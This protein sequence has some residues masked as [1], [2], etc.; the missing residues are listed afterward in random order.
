VLL[1]A[2]Y[3]ATLAPGLTFWDA[4]ELIAAVETLGIPHPPGTPLFVVL[5]RAWSDVL[6]WL[7]RAHATNLLSAVCTAAAGGVL[8][9]VVTRWSGRVLMGIAAALAAGAMS[10][11][12]R[13]ATETEL[14][15][16]SLLLSMLMLAAGHRAGVTGSGK[17]LILTAYTFALAVPLHL[18]ALVAAPG[19]ALLAAQDTR[20]GIRWGDAGLLASAM[21]LSLAVGLASPALIAASLGVVG[22]A[23]VSQERRPPSRALGGIA[24]MVVAFSALA[25]MAARAVHEPAINS[26]NPRDWAALWDVVGRRQYGGHALWPRQ[27]PLWIQLGNLAEYADWQVALGLSPGVAPSLVR[28]PITLLFVALGIA[29]ASAH[30]RADPRSWRAMLL[31]LVAGSLALALYLNF[32][33]GASFGWGVLPDDAPHEARERDYFFTLA[34]WTWGAWAGMGAVWVFRRAHARLAPL[35]LALA[36]LPVLLNWSAVDRRGG[37]EAHLPLEVA[38]A[39]LASAPDRAVLV[40]AGDNDSFPL[41]YAQQVEQ[42]RPDVTVVVA[43]L[44]GARW[45]V[46]QL[47]RRDTL[48]DASVAR[49]ALGDEWSFLHAVGDGARSR[50]RPVA[51]ALNAGLARAQAVGIDEPLLRGLV[52]VQASA[53]EGARVRELPWLVD[54]ATTGRLAA[55]LPTIVSSRDAIDP[56]ARAFSALLDCPR[57]IVAAARAGVEPISLDS[58][59]NPR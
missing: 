49:S 35:G 14:Y 51:V 36:A 42:L 8:A 24:V 28:T 50:G 52:L 7:P 17:W 11:V 3:V 57:Q 47:A 18:G 58:R 22:A 33:P 21:L 46:E 27:A 20:G 34:L 54:T 6:A 19:A 37:A 25:I 2:L 38:R 59:C 10:T 30:R 15:A 13:N 16:A 44:L 56:T 55:A 26:G 1:G 5:A 23:I 43:P 4:G 31:T 12:W 9:W 53:E 48:L 40:T 29:G 41:W 32:K 45:Y 39:L